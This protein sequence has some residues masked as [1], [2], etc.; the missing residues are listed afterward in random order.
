[1]HQYE[2]GLFAIQLNLPNG[3]YEYKYRV[4]DTIWTI[5]QETTSK[6]EANGVLNNILN[7]DVT[8]FVH[9]NLVR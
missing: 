5:S 7:L 8:Q 6:L 9:E 1:M 3:A 4:N 2:N